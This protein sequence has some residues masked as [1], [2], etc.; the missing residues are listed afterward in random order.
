MN[1]RA[2]LSDQRPRF[3]ANVASAASRNSGLRLCGAVKGSRPSSRAARRLAAAM[4]R[5]SASVRRGHSPSPRSTRLPLTVR[6]CANAREPDGCTTTNSFLQSE[7]AWRPA[8]TM[9]LGGAMKLTQKRVAPSPGRR[10]ASGPAERR[11]VRRA[12]KR[13]AWAGGAAGVDVLPRVSG[14]GD[15]GVPVECGTLE[16]TQRIAGRASP[17]TTKLYDPDSGS[18][19]LTCPPRPGGTTDMTGTTRRRG[20]W[21]N[22]RDE[23]AVNPRRHRTGHAGEQLK[24]QYEGSASR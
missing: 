15:H 12:C 19:V 6:R 21:T 1:A 11:P 5:A 20:V 4:A 14:D 3:A 23:Q 16:Y 9:V 17:R 24:T 7:S 22:A 13:R 18:P 2:L 10:E 8:E